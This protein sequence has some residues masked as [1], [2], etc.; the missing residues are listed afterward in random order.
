MSVEL[1]HLRYF[2][3]LAEAESFG[4]A[5]TTLG[6]AQPALSQQ[7]R[8]L[9]SELDVVLFRRGNDGARLTP[10]GEAF[11]PGARA[12]VSD[13]LRAV[14]CAQRVGC[15][16]SGCL[17]VGFIGSAADHLAPA[18]LRLFGRE[19]PEVEVSLI[20]TDPSELP[21]CFE[22]NDFDVAFAHRPVDDPTLLTEPVGVDDVVAVL[23]DDHSLSGEQSI[24]LSAL[25]QDAWVLAPVSMSRTSREMFLANCSRSGF[26]PTIR[27]EASTPEAIIGL[28]AAGLGVSMVPKGSHSLPRDGVCTVPIQGQESV[29]VMVW[30]ED[31]RTPPASDFMRLM[32]EIAHPVR[33][34]TGNEMESAN[35]G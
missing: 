35:W 4:R 8:K 18:A 11:L 3:A 32:R 5:A 23:P 24:P 10:A 7:I 31:R 25:A 22:R 26:M 34:A 27:A 20:E 14:A 15:G 2:I 13:A 12:S 19:R 1:R 30:R 29:V 21:G 33:I 17:N 6:I 9:E 16:E 28:V